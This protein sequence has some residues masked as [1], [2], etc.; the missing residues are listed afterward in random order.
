MGHSAGSHL[1]AMLLSGAWYDGLPLRARKRVL[2]V[3][4]LSGVFQLHPLLK[5]SVNIPGLGLSA[6]TVQHYS[7][8]HTENLAKLTRGGQHLVSLVVVGEADSPAFH[9][10][11]EEYGDSLEAAGMRVVRST[12]PREDHFSLVEKLADS[13]YSLTKDILRLVAGLYSLHT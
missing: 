10:Q 8:G 4:H 11:A 2:G 12:V 6:G 13:N 3:V 7:P 5:T 9:R 1:C